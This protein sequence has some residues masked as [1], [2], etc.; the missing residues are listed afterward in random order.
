MDLSALGEFGLISRIRERAQGRWSQLLLGIGGDAAA[1]RPSEGSI[2]LATTDLL[3]EGIHFFRDIPPPHL[4]GMKALAVNISDIAAMGGVPRV[5]LIS[6][7][8]SPDEQVESIDA[9]YAGMEEEAS[10]YGVSLV[11]G[12]TSLSPG[13]LFINVA[14]LGEGKEGCWIR[15]SGARDGDSLMVTGALGASAAGLAGIKAALELDPKNTGSLPPRDWRR[16]QGL[17]PLTREA[18][19]EAV[20][21]H[22]LPTPRV[23]EGQL[24]AQEGWASAMIDLSDGLASDLGHLCGESGVGAVIWERELPVASCVRAVA[25]ELGEDPVRLATQGGEDY[26]LLFATSAPDQVEKAFREAGLAPVRRIGEVLGQP[27]Q[28]NLQRQDGALWPLVGG[29]DHFRSH[30]D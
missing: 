7:A 12:D 25:R 23:R 15:R 30:R 6:L 18:F 1:F 9:L 29:F 22:F 28:M 11:G 10:V 21:A 26:E 20:E 17:D 16:F 27:G 14:L 4:L 13:P 3:L 24:L 8:L 2:L 19:Q 5:A